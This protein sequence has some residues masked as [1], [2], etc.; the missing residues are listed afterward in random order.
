[1]HIVTFTGSSESIASN[2]D[3]EETKGEEEK[4][5][6]GLELGGGDEVKL[7]VEESSGMRDKTEL[8]SIVSGGKDWFCEFFSSGM[9]DWEG[10]RCGE[11]GGEGTV[12]SSI[13]LRPDESKATESDSFWI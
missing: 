8:S 5:L 6:A 13:E 10:E 3:W 12:E 1:M 4:I 7:F 2:E 9:D 11:A